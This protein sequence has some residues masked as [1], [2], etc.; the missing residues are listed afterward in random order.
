MHLAIERYDW[1]EHLSL[2]DNTYVFERYLSNRVPPID[3][4]RRVI[5]AQSSS[6]ERGYA[7]DSRLSSG[8][9]GSMFGTDSRAKWQTSLLANLWITKD[10]RCTYDVDRVFAIRALSSDV[11]STEL[12]PEASDYPSNGENNAASQE[13]GVVRVF[14]A[15]ARRSIIQYNDLRILGACQLMPNAKYPSL[16]SW[17]P[18]WSLGSKSR[19]LRYLIPLDPTAQDQYDK[20][21]FQALQPRSA[22][23]SFDELNVGRLTLVGYTVQVVW[24]TGTDHSVGFTDRESA[25][26]NFMDFLAEGERMVLPMTGRT[27]SLP[28]LQSAWTDESLLQALYRTLCMDMDKNGQRLGPKKELS[29]RNAFENPDSM[30]DAVALTSA[31]AFGTKLRKFF[32]TREGDMGCGPCATQPGD[33]VCL[34]PGAIVPLMLRDV[35][36][37]YVVVGECYCHTLMDGAAVPYLDVIYKRKE[38]VL[39]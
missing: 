7:K 4:T 31:M 30:A 9:T 8:L 38:F 35:G 11:S 34:I 28:Y 17:A 26:A 12:L 23:Y 3:L 39:G 37:H 29:I 10:R 2:E 19:P 32:T 22:D 18:D 21:P 25:A 15:V 20:P 16:P 36:D 14:T 5:Q 13:M 6:D 33:L 24:N 1:G 27:A